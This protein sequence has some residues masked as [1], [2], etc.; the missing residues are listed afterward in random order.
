MLMKDYLDPTATLSAFEDQKTEKGGY[1][2][3]GNTKTYSTSYTMNDIIHD[4]FG[5]NYSKKS[6]EI[7]SELKRRTPS[8]YGNYSSLSQLSGKDLK[9]LKDLYVYTPKPGKKGGVAIRPDWLGSEIGALVKSRDRL[10][11]KQFTKYEHKELNDKYFQDQLKKRGEGDFRTS[12][13]NYAVNLERDRSLGD[14]ITNR[15]SVRDKTRDAIT[16]QLGALGIQ[17]QNVELN[18]LGRFNLINQLQEQFGPNYMQNEQAANIVKMFDSTIL[19]GED[20]ESLDRIFSGGKE[21]N[22]FLSSDRYT[23]SNKWL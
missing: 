19:Q 12:D 13:F 10:G 15:K 14:I 5:M 20:I 18:G 8:K 9:D 3:S 2:L 7:L 21:I 17:G 11:V 1:E 16:Q 6:S 23:S 4:A 22:D